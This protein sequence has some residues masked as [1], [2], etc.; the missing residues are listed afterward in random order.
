MN[1]SFDTRD[2]IIAALRR[3]IRAVDRHSKFL[4]QRYGLTGPQ[5]VVLQFIEQHGPQTTSQLARGVSLGQATLSDILERLERKNLIERRRSKADKRRVINELTAAGRDALEKA[6]PLL[7]ERFV[8]ELQR[9][10]DW[11]Q[12]Q[13]LSTLQRVA[14]MMRAQDIE[15]SPVLVSGPVGVSAEETADFLTGQEEGEES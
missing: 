2:E 12:T 1:G 3:I 15:A 11:E 9:L 14:E 10:A 7:Q 13:I 6:P 8:K 4:A 5:L